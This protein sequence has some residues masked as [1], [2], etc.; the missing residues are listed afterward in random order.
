MLWN[1]KFLL[2]VKGCRKTQVSDCTNSTEYRIRAVLKEERDT[3]TSVAASLIG[4]VRILVI[5]Y[6]KNFKTDVIVSIDN[7]QM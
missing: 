4:Q 3:I 6:V 5:M 2:D 1:H 7:V